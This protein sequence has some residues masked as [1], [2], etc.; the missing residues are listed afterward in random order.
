MSR[1]DEKDLKLQK[2]LS[3]YL[4]DIHE[5]LTLDSLRGD[6]LPNMSAILDTSHFWMSDH[7]RFWYHL[8]ANQKLY[9]LGGILIS[10]TGN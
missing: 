9:N 3:K 6:R 4:D 5:P 7:A 2:V 8:E 10:D 1:K